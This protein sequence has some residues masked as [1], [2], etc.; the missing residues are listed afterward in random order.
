MAKVFK[1]LA[2]F[3]DANGDY[4]D[5]EHFE[6]QLLNMIDRTD[7]GIYIAEAYESEE[8]E[9]HDEVNINYLNATE[10]DF[11][12]YFEKKKS[13]AEIS[14]EHLHTHG[15][16]YE[17]VASRFEYDVEIDIKNKDE[18]FVTVTNKSTGETK[19]KKTQVLFSSAEQQG[20]AVAR[21]MIDEWK[22]Q[23][24]KPRVIKYESN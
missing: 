19:H 12:E 17:K 8:F 21:R 24:E 11:E 18:I 22:Y 4:Q 5:Q 14:K 16:E 7:L 20:R 3:T 10:E 6:S 2:Y 15:K 9:W 23:E 13:G 1:I